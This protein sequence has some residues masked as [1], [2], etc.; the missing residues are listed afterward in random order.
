[1]NCRIL[2]CRKLHVTLLFRTSRP[3]LP[4]LGSSRIASS[5]ETDYRGSNGCYS[6]GYHCSLLYCLHFVADSAGFAVEVASD[7]DDSCV[8]TLFA[9]GGAVIAVSFGQS[10]GQPRPQPQLGTIMLSGGAQ[11]VRL[12]SHRPRGDNCCFFAAMVV[13]WA[14]VRAVGPYCCCGGT[15]RGTAAGTTA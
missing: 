5:C 3:I 13:V 7:D 2:A 6:H 12:Y 11:A 10:C 4:T 9:A 15:D 8:E 14:W 1:M